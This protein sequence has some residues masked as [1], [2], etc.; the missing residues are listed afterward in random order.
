MVWCWSAEAGVCKQLSL[1]MCL[2][3]YSFV[4]LVVVCWKLGSSHTCVLIYAALFTVTNL[5]IKLHSTS[6]TVIFMYEYIYNIIN[7]KHIPLLI[8][9]VLLIIFSFT[10]RLAV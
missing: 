10:F 7:E 2:W 1:D 6:H 5:L 4:V 9:A 8:N 3:Y